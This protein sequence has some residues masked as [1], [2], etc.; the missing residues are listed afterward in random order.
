M[1]KTAIIDGDMV[2]VIGH[3]WLDAHG[4]PRH[5]IGHGKDKHVHRT[6]MEYHLGRKLVSPEC[7]HHINGNKQDNR[8]E[9]LQL[10]AN[11]KEH[12]RI[13]AIQDVIR[14]GYDPE[15]H[16][17]CTYHKRYECKTQFSSVKSTWTGL[18]NMCREATNEYRKLRGL[19]RDKFDWRARLNQQYRRAMKKGIISPLK[20]GSCL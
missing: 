16:H 17:Y 4:Y 8:L 10:C 13:H 7:I 18:H 20:E 2:D 15:T 11:E 6:V 19:N 9:N 12:S 1:S 3:Y 14:D 5:S